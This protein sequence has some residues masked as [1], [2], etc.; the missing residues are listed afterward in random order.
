MLLLLNQLVEILLLLLRSHG[1]HVL[2]EVL[3]NLLVVVCWWLLF[4]H[5]LVLNLLLLGLNLLLLDFLLFLLLFL[6][7]LLCSQ[8]IKKTKSDIT[9]R[10]RGLIVASSLSQINVSNS[11]EF[12]SNHIYLQFHH[13][14]LSEVHV[15]RTSVS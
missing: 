9:S 5:L 15:V 13:I 12:R 4:L 1:L 6:N 7:F 8:P 14:L 3:N 11:I 10:I 2:E